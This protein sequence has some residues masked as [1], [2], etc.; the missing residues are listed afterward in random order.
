MLEKQISKELVLFLER[1]DKFYEDFLE[2]ERNKYEAITRNDLASLDCFVTKEQ[3]LYLK[4]RGLESERIQ[5]MQQCSEPQTSFRN[6]IPILDSEFQQKATEIFNHLSDVLL[7]LKQVNSSCNSL[8]EL[9][10]HRIDI[11]LK[12]LENQPEL[13]KEYNRVAKQS[14]KGTHVISKKI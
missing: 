1:Y 10:L 7:N 12:H 9:R 3:A 5:L 11:N 6:L 4:S 13:Q 8:T 2:L 14:S